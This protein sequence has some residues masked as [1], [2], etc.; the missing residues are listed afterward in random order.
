MCHTQWCNS[1]TGVSAFPSAQCWREV[2]PHLSD[3]FA[4]SVP[5]SVPPII[6]NYLSQLATCECQKCIVFAANNMNH[7]LDRAP[8]KRST[9][10]HTSP[11]SRWRLEK[12]MNMYMK[13]RYRSLK[14]NVE[15]QHVAQGV[16]YVVP[17]QT[18]YIWSTTPYFLELNINMQ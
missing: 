4:I 2:A 1:N 17:S 3:M 11:V 5:P 7:C 15:G 12:N 10:P 13:F 16:I 18:T 8:H 14:I 9:H 6:L